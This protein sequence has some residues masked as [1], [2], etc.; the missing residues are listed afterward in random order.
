[1][2]AAVL[3]VSDRAAAG[4]YQDES[5]PAAVD[6]LRTRLHVENIATAVVPDNREEI[7]RALLHWVE[8]EGVQ[9]VLTSGGTGI[10]PQDVTPQATL[11]VLDYEIPGL[12]EVM[13]A[14]SLTMTPMA[15]LSRALAGVRGRTLIIN[16]PGSPRAVK[17]CLEAIL[18]VLPHAMSQLEGGG[19]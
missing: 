16:L 4:V 3:T 10:S 14:A 11:N 9:L 13:R 15:A 8:V 2:K 19:H 5:G 7:E 18:S 17:E 6:F 1:M 12:A